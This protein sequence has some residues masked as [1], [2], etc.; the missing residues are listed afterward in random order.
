M[1]DIYFDNSATTAPLEEAVACIN[2]LCTSIWGNPSS[3]HRKGVDAEAALTKARGEILSALGAKNISSLTDSRLIFT[4]SGTEADNLALFG[5]CHAKKF[6]PGKK[7]IISDSEH[8]AI[9]E[10]ASRLE[11]E[12]YTVVRIPTKGGALDYDMLEECVDKNTVIVS[13]MLVNNETGAINDIKRVS[14]T[15]KQKNSDTLVHTDAV[16]G[17][18]KIKFTPSSLGADLI[19]ISSH[20]IHGPKGV[21]ALYVDPSVLK[22]RR[23]VPLIYGGGQERGLRSGTENTLGIAGF[24]VAAKLGAQRLDANIAAMTSLRDYICDQIR[25]DDGLSSVT[26][27]LPSVE[28]AHHIISLRLPGIK[29][30][31][32]LHFLSSEGIYVSSGSACSS[33]TGHISNALLCFG[34]TERE[35]DSTLR[36]SLCADNT[37]EEADIFLNTLKRGLS[38]LVSN[39][40]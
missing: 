28:R 10:S 25:T 16:Q 11:S 31:T 39:K 4:S 7:I 12:G 8:P 33:N 23:L 26:L 17:F 40:K 35:A 37:R 2:E 24:G 38:K 5:A 34:L 6:T 15:V 14:H 19:T 3:M 1:N 21:G 18:L 36:I 32:M 13:I 22:A 27:N 9:L 20:K 30:E 29:S